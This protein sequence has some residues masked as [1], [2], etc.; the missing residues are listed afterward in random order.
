M[1]T[2]EIIKKAQ[3]STEWYKYIIQNDDERSIGDYSET[4]VRYAPSP[5]GDMH[6]GG[7]R[8][9]LFNYLFAKVNKG[10]FILRIE[11]TDKKRE[12]E[13]A[14]QKI[15]DVMRWA[16]LNW[17]EG[18]GAK[19]NGTNFEQGGE[20]GPYYQSQRLGTYKKWAETL[21]ESKH[22]YHCFWSSDRLKELKK[23]QQKSKGSWTKYDRLCLGLTEDEVQQ[24]INAGEKYVI[25]M[26][27][28]EGKT[29]FKDIIHGNM[30]FNNTQLDDQ[31]LL[32]SDGYPTYHLAN[33]VDDFLMG[34]S[35]VIRGEEWLPST[36]KHIILY[37]MLNL[38][39]P[40][41]AHIPLI[42]NNKGAKLSKRHGDTSVES[43][44]EKG[45]LPETILNS[46]AL[47][48]WSPPSHE[49]IGA[50]TGDLKNF[51]ESE[52][53]S[54]KDLEAYFDILK[55]TKSPSKFDIEKFKFFNSNFIR[56]KYV[57]YTP[58]ERKESTLR[59][60]KLWM[61]ILPESLH[62]NIRGFEYKKIAKVMDLMIP[63]IQFYGDL[64]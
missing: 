23:S 7:L 11:D 48:G 26:L 28:P 51:L 45:Y 10:T 41:F 38:N 12:V 47:L 1:S 21:V 4:R 5:T 37:N 16:G 18:V 40:T 62:T 15:V 25:R 35:H 44:R 8:T 64:K 30:S 36:P 46:L 19:Y 58:E 14:D 55:I 43:F 59:F 57:Y 32:K 50:M 49:D 20:F 29:T 39:P 6:I 3:N 52:I 2:E 33:I 27:I 13:G 9:A 22:A 56:K 34:I 63:R 31:V 42:V 60:R 61:Q 54:L 53:L 17:D 24:K